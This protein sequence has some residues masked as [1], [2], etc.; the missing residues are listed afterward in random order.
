MTESDFDFPQRINKDRADFQKIRDQ[1]YQNYNDRG[2]DLVQ[3]NQYTDIFSDGIKEGSVRFEPNKNGTGTL[4]IDTLVKHKK[5]TK[6]LT[7]ENKDEVAF[8]IGLQESLRSPEE[9]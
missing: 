8:F 1:F 7:I 4:F 6:E 9:K 2:V 3:L 5:V